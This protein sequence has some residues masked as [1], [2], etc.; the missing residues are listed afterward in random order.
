MGREAE[1]ITRVQ[2]LVG[3]H[4]KIWNLWF[5]LGWA[6]RR[7][8]QYAEGRGSLEKALELDPGNS[9]T[10]NELAIC[11]MEL[12]DY[13]QSKKRLLQALE[14]EPKNVKLLS[15]LGILSMKTGENSEAARCFQQVLQYEPE[16]PLAS[17]YLELL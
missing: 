10:L 8:Q 4:P 13:K 14:L 17:R 11:L 2:S 9:D 1:A 12:G 5:L 7:S 16:D 3:Q 6:Q 15:N